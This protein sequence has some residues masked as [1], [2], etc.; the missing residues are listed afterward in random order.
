M[1]WMVN[2][3]LED[4]RGG[5][6]LRTAVRGVLAAGGRAREGQEEEEEEGR[7]GD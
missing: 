1:N 6:E 3:W 2:L 5:A 4:E 7:S